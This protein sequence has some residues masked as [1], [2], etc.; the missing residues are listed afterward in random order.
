MVSILVGFLDEKIKQVK[1]ELSYYESMADK[2]SNNRFEGN[3]FV[4]YKITE[5]DHELGN[6][7]AVQLSIILCDERNT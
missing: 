7:K 1:N 3:A 6:L 5:L 4:N 2:L